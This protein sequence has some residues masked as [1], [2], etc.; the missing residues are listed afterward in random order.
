LRGGLCDDL[1]NWTG[2]NCQA[3]RHLGASVARVPLGWNRVGW[4]EDAE[5]VV[6]DGIRTIRD[7]SLR[8]LICVWFHTNEQPPVDVFAA[9]AVRYATL[10]PMAM[11]Q[12]LNEPQH[13][14]TGDL[15]PDQTVAY[16]NAAAEA[17]WAVEPKAKLLAPALVPTPGWIAYFEAMWEDFPHGLEPA[18]H[19]YPRQDRPLDSIEMAYGMAKKH[20]PVHVTE[21]GFIRSVYGANRQADLTTA[22]LKLLRRLGAATTVVYR[23]AKPID[24]SEWEDE[25]DLSVLDQARL[26][27][28]FREGM[29]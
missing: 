1:A 22:A 28:A 20:G 12:L 17:V 5:Q 24:S 10:F 8:P 9:H 29:N 6:R 23:L 4:G 11:L 27:R 7:A 18:L 26:R 3:A 2:E 15:R 16:V 19:L 25:A 13:E 21:M 14:S